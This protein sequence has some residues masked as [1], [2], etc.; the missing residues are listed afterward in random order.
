MELAAVENINSIPK[1]FW[2]LIRHNRDQILRMP[3][4]LLEMVVRTLKKFRPVEP[5]LDLSIRKMETKIREG[6]K[7]TYGL[8]DEHLQI[9]ER[10]ARSP[11][12][13]SRWQT[14]KCFSLDLLIAGMASLLIGIGLSLTAST[15]T[16]RWAPVAISCLVVLI[17]VFLGKARLAAFN[18]HRNLRDIARIIRD[19]LGCRFV[20]FG[21]SHDPDVYPLSAS[22]DQWYF[23]V[24]TWALRSKEA[25]FVY[26]EIINSPISPSAH[27]MRWDRKSEQPLELD[28]ASYV[29][30]SAEREAMLAGERAGLR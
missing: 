16:W 13:L 24:G 29:K 19:T 20:V 1:S 14:I 6:L 10:L 25:Q 28:M 7:A 2:H 11:V 15:W 8:S 5:A 3:F 18:D 23:N 17:L 21:H 26:L 9:I 22:K 4:Y 30:G 27:L 12:L